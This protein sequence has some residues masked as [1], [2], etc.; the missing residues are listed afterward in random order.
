MKNIICISII[1]LFCVC[2]NFSIGQVNWVSMKTSGDLP[3]NAIAGGKE[4]GQVQYV[5]RAKLGDG[6]YH[7][8]KLFKSSSGWVCNCA[9]GDNEI[10]NRSFDVLI[11]DG[12]IAPQWRKLNEVSDKLNSIGVV[13]IDGHDNE[14]YPCVYDYYRGLRHYGRHIGKLW[15]GKC[16][17]GYGG[18]AIKKDDSDKI[19]VLTINKS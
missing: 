3:N 14:L 19:L 9:G 10:V 15:K 6:G 1:F 7:P 8:G 16:E 11:Q 2:P 13:T 5:C 17:F 12:P 18:T 4:N